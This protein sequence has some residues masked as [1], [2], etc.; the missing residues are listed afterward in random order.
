M[1]SLDMIQ[2]IAPRVLYNCAFILFG[3]LVLQEH[4]KA[5]RTIVVLLFTLTP[6]REG[7]CS[8]SDSLYALLF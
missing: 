7:Y 4:H 5:L 3:K 2:T 6:T 1:A 8:Q